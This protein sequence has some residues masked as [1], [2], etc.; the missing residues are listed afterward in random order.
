MRRTGSRGQGRDVDTA[1][2]FANLCIGL[3]ASAEMSRPSGV[4][5]GTSM[6][7]PDMLWVT[8]S[9]GLFARRSGPWFSHCG[10]SKPTKD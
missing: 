10:D 8:M 5:I 9:A 3:R 1:R 4:G 2:R 6:V 7:C